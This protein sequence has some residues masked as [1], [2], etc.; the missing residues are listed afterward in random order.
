[1]QISLDRLTKL[2]G[3]IGMAAGAVAA[4]HFWDTERLR[5]SLEVTEEGAIIP[6]LLNFHDMKCSGGVP[7]KFRGDMIELEERWYELNGRPFDYPE[8]PDAD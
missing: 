1:M 5:E 7:H 6:R 2:G 8:C 4:F 3:L